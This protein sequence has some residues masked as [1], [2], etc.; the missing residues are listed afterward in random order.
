MS[1][2]AVFRVR[3]GRLRLAESGLK[4]LGFVVYAP[5][6][7][8]VRVHHGKRHKHTRQMLGSY[9][10]ISVTEEWRA[11]RKLPS[12]IGYIRGASTAGPVPVPDAVIEALRARERD[13]PPARSG[14]RLAVGDPVRVVGGPFAERLGTCAAVG[15]NDV[16][17]LISVFG[18]EREIRIRRAAVRRL[19]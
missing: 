16:V 13:G 17:V 3:A 7:S 8:E 2:W 5:R 12:V 15:Q 10:F 6:W 9:V 19:C 11:V 18:A 4:A 14:D 1:Y